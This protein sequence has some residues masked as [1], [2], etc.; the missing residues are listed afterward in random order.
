MWLYDPAAS[1]GLPVSSWSPLAASTTWL[2]ARRMADGLCVAGRAAPGHGA[3][4]TPT[5]GTPQRPSSWRRSCSPRPGRGGGWPMSC[6][7]ST[8]QEVEEVAALLEALART[9][10]SPG[11]AGHLAARRP[12]AQLGLH[13]RRDGAR[14]LR[15]PDARGRRRRRDRTEIDPDRLLDGGHHTLYLCAPAHEQ[16]R[17]RP[18]FAALVDQCSRP[19]TTGGQPSAARSIRRCWSCSTRRPTSPRSPSSTSWPATAAGQGIQ[20][21]TVWQDLAQ[22]SARYGERAATVVN[23]HRA[24]VVLSGISDPATLDHLSHL[25]GEEDVLQRLDDDGRPRAGFDHA[26]D[27]PPPAGAGRQP[28]AYPARSRRARLRPPSAGAPGAAPLVRRPPPD[29]PGPS[30]RGERS[31]RHGRAPRPRLSRR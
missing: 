12:A 23:N 17:L 30:G 10:R 26:I 24:K 19:S 1:T 22:I 16:Q 21:V 20:L 6:G 15:R 18:L 31:G 5:S 27:Q 8:T 14:R 2:G 13:H 4:P 11:G 29:P 25:V 28:A 3:R 7:G 9:G